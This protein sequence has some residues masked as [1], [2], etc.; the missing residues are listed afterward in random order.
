M[1]ESDDVTLRPVYSEL[2]V[3]DLCG[4]SPHTIA[5]PRHE[6]YDD[7]AWCWFRI[8]APEEVGPA[9]YWVEETFAAAASDEGEDTEAA[10]HEGMQ[11]FERAVREG[12]L[13]R[14]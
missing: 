5:C 10:L 9:R 4:G 12:W 7:D 6:R 1:N 14:E 3:C 2:E 11:E 8:D 13:R